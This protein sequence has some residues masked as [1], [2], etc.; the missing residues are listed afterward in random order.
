MGSYPSV[1]PYLTSVVE[2]SSFTTF[3]M[4]RSITNRLVIFNVVK[5]DGFL[6]TYL[7]LVDLRRPQ[8]TLLAGFF[9]IYSLYIFIYQKWS[10]NQIT[11]LGLSLCLGY[12]YAILIALPRLSIY[13]DK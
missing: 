3:I 6:G 5:R 7:D 4:H 8:S 10:H 11:Y 13:I 2:Q 12:L 1:L 9:N